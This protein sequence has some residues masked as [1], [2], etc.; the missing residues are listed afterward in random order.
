MLGYLRQLE[1]W[2]DGENSVHYSGI[3]AE[4]DR[5]LMGGTFA[6]CHRTSLFKSKAM[7]P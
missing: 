3:V 7:Q 2:R 1:A 6:R 5:V 4:F